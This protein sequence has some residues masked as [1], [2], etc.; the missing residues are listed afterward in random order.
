MLKNKEGGMAMVVPWPEASPAITAH[1]GKVVMCVAH[2]P[3]GLGGDA[4][5]T[6]PRL[7]C[8]YGLVIAWDDE[9]L[10]PLGDDP[11]VVAATNDAIAA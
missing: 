11:D 1:A 9:D 5:T 6:E 2:G 3:C 4:W 7:R 8:E 10:L